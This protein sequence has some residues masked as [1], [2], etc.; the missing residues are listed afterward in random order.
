MNIVNFEDFLKGKKYNWFILQAQRKWEAD[1]EEHR[2]RKRD[3]EITMIEMEQVQ[4]NQL[5]HIL[6]HFFL[7]LGG[8][9]T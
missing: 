7:S 8:S 1:E 2:R 9:N 3:Y 4:K 6:A 5:N